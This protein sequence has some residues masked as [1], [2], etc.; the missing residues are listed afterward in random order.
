[1]RRVQLGGCRRASCPHILI[2]LG[3]RQHLTSLLLSFQGTDLRTGDLKGRVL[4]GEWD[5]VCAHLGWAQPGG[6]AG[7]IPALLGM[8]LD[9]PRSC[10]GWVPL[11]VGLRAVMESLN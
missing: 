6:H 9:R 5:G 2:L 7:A 11:A 3:G 4:T 1:M 10:R 8:F